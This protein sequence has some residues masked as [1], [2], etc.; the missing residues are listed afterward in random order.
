[1]NEPRNILITGAG[2]GLGRGLSID[3]ARMGHRIVATD[4]DEAAARQTVAQLPD[5]GLERE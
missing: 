3:L 2:S 4:L 1:M 5:P